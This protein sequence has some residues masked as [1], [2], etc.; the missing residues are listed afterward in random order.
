MCV[1]L[2]LWRAALPASEL[3]PHVR[4]FP[5]HRSSPGAEDQ[6]RITG[7]AQTEDALTRAALLLVS[8]EESHWNIV[9]HVI[10]G[11]PARW[12]ATLGLCAACSLLGSGVASFAH[13]CVMLLAFTSMIS[14]ATRF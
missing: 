3:Q 6:P 13:A 14:T 2:L 4:C 10:K 7:V 12:A 9:N 1:P 11:S 5:S 8:V